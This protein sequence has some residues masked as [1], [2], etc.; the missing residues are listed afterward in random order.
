MGYLS[1]KGK[2]DP[3]DGSEVGRVVTATRSPEHIGPG[4]ALSP[5]LVPERLRPLVFNLVSDS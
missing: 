1:R 3:E 2:N 4:A 5:W